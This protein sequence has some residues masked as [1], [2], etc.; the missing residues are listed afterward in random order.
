MKALLATSSLQTPHAPSKNPRAIPKFPL[1]DS[2]SSIAKQVG[3]PSS[4]SKQVAINSFSFRSQALNPS[5]LLAVT[6]TPSANL[7]SIDGT[8]GRSATWISWTSQAPTLQLYLNLYCF[9]QF[10]S[11]PSLRFKRVLSS[12]HLLLL[13]EKCSDSSGAV[14]MPGILKARGS[15]KRL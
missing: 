5:S 2:G 14:R 8:L 4:S 12:S 11:L 13:E 10:V 6:T 15:T 9:F 7:T 3:V 1:P